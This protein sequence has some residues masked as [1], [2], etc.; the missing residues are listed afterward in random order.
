MAGESPSTKT[1]YVYTWPYQWVYELVYWVLAGLQKTERWKFEFVTGPEEG[2]VF[3]SDEAIQD[4]FLRSTKPLKIALCEPP[5]ERG[6]RL[7]PFLWR[8]PVW[9]FVP[10]YWWNLLQLGDNPR[11][12][13]L[14][15]KVLSHNKLTVYRFPD[16]A[17]TGRS[18]MEYLNVHSRRFNLANSQEKRIQE[19][20]ELNLD[21][22]LQSS[23]SENANE[24]PLAFS[25]TP[26]H[27]VH[28]EVM[29][30][31]EIAGIAGR[32]TAVILPLEKDEKDD[33]REMIVEL[34]DR[35]LLGIKNFISV[36]YA[37]TDFGQSL[38]ILV[39]RHADDIKQMTGLGTRPTWCQADATVAL[40][41]A[42]YVT[43]GCFFPYCVLDAS[44]QLDL[45][46]I[47]RD[48]LNAH[49]DRMQN[50]FHDQFA[51][52]V[53]PGLV[54]TDL[55]PARRHSILTT[56]VSPPKSNTE[57]STTLADTLLH[58]SSGES[59]F[60]E[61]FI[62]DPKETYVPLHY[63]RFAG[64]ENNTNTVMVCNDP[65]KCGLYPSNAQFPCL[66]CRILGGQATLMLQ[67]D[68]CLQ[69]KL[70]NNVN[71]VSWYNAN[72]SQEWQSG[73]FRWS[74]VAF[75]DLQT[76]CHIF[77]ETF[78]PK[79]QGDVKPQVGAN[80]YCLDGDE[81]CC[82][83]A[84]QVVFSIQTSHRQESNT[85]PKGNNGNAKVRLRKW[86]EKCRDRVID[87]WLYYPKGW[88]DDEKAKW[89][90]ITED[91]SINEEPA[92]AAKLVTARHFYPWC[93][94]AYVAVVGIPP[95][96]AARAKEPE[97]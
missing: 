22:F 61:L 45:F 73:G 93:Y 59:G 27:V 14:I 20:K 74:V 37:E 25:F 41:L 42:M 97:E 75:E 33:D 84:K 65:G 69:N 19:Y 91:S 48:T 21:T 11:D 5:A 39:E 32:V 8:L 9:G 3:D 92:W 47:F 95:S 44:L 40:L 57:T 34:R 17:T 80:L 63:V 96:D 87:S 70:S 28:G 71:L 88:K 78:T 4:E 58:H 38:P 2:K 89:F 66:A 64:D 29:R 18:A 46:K 7:V 54:W 77:R 52:F 86:K 67:V 82:M 1:V 94:F 72:K 85:G 16:K 51:T 81:A 24:L 10:R 60:K 55:S 83:S 79:D 13:E 62:E 36:L 30:V 50:W 15:K 53:S 23:Q 49:A 90:H 31:C 6:Y 26:L 12:P 76:L 35:L 68:Q 43:R 56:P